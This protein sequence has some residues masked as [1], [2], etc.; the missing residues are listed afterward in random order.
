MTS[1]TLL[2]HPLTRAAAASP[3]VVPA[4]LGRRLAALAGEGLMALAPLLVVPLLALTR[5]PIGWAWLVGC[6]GVLGVAAGGAV[7]NLRKASDTRRRVDAWATPY[8]T[9]SIMES[10]RDVMRW[11]RM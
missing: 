3:G 7:V 5:L 11:P 2:R 1:D 4:D 8:T 9:R 10:S 6:L